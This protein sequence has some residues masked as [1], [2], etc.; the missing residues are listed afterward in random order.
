[1]SV[2]TSTCGSH[3]LLGFWV[4]VFVIATGQKSA[5]AIM[6]NCC[7]TQIAADLWLAKLARFAIMEHFLGSIHILITMIKLSNSCCTAASPKTQMKF[8]LK[9]QLPRWSTEFEKL[10]LTL[11][12]QKL[13]LLEQNLHYSQSSA[14]FNSSVAMSVSL[15]DFY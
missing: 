1:M 11:K 9:R 12:R 15:V 2:A 8:Q 4:A 10:G 13:G 3:K 5:I 6:K 7:L 14:A